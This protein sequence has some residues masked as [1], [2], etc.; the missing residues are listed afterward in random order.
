MI[1]KYSLSLNWVAMANTNENI[2]MIKKN[3]ILRIGD[4]I[5]WENSKKYRVWGLK[6]K[7][8]SNIKKIRY[9]DILWFIRGKGGV[10]V[11]MAEFICFYDKRDE[12]L[13]NINTIDNY[14]L[15]YKGEESWDI[16]IRYK[17]L[18]TIKKQ[19]I[20]ITIKYSGSVISYEDFLNYPTYREKLREVDLYLHYNNIIFY[21]EPEF[22]EFQYI[23]K[24]EIFCTNTNMIETENQNKKCKH[25]Y[26]EEDRKK[27]GEQCSLPVKSGLYCIIHKKKYN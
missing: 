4:G 10:V 19:N 18:Y 8:K 16:Q 24:P 27:G 21:T 15:G 6:K 11:G 3:Y 7:W 13:V 1:F 20:L 5:H 26:P 2:S 25:I 17:N 14:E 12:P 23:N 9:G 22:D